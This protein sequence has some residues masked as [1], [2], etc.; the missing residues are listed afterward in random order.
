[1]EPDMSVHGTH[2]PVNVSYP[3]WRYNETIPLYQAMHALGVPI[4]EDVNDGTAG[5]TYLPLD[6]DPSTQTRSTAR[7]AYYDPAASR[8][9]LYVTTGQ[10]VTRVLFEDQPG[11]EGAASGP[12]NGAGSAADSNGIFGP[13]PTASASNR[14]RDFLHQGQ[15]SARNSTCNS[16]LLHAIGVEVRSKSHR[17]HLFIA[18]LCSRN[19]ANTILVCPKRCSCSHERNRSTRGYHSRWQFSFPPTSTI[20]WCWSTKP[21]FR[22]RHSCIKQSGRCGIQL[23]GSLHD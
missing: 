6:L 4:A 23:A 15:H 11:E 16:T 8:P 17:R 18:L 3:N 21:P 14:R 10:T 9:N 13:P 19:R 2:G 1:M 7:K 12:Q 20:V 5:I 22:I